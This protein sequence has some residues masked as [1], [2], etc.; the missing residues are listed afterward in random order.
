[1]EKRTRHEFQIK[2]VYDEPSAGDGLRF[3]VD[4]LW[5]RG[6]KKEALRATGW[7]KDVAPSPSLR[8]W[9]GHEKIRWEEFSRCYRAELAAR[10]DTWAP[11]LAAIKTDNVTL[12][13]AARDRQ[14]NHAAVLKD[15][16]Q[17]QRKQTNRPKKGT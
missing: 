7:L 9:F 13:Y 6:L 11:L 5:P 16:L 2:R 1:M 8:E 12:L 10:P 3:L 17:K 4:R 15:F 14:I